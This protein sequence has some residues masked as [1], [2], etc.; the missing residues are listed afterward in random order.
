[1]HKNSTNKQSINIYKKR[2]KND[3]K[4]IAFIFKYTKIL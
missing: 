4:L 2:Y 3:R 1:M